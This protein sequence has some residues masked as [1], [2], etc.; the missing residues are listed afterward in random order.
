MY[1]RLELALTA[2]EVAEHRLRLFAAWNMFL[3]SKLIGTNLLYKK[4]LPD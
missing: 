4:Y 1:E 2:I 3:L